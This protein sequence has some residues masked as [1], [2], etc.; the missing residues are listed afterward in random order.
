MPQSLA[1]VVVH[2][3]FSTKNRAPLLKSPE[4]R[5][6]LH[7]YSVGTLKN[8][9]CRSIITRSVEDHI[10][11]LCHLSRTM[12]IAQLIKEIKA[13][14][15]AWLKEQDPC[16]HDFYWQAGYGAFSVSRSNVEKVKDYIADQEEHHRTRTFQEEFRLLLE[17][18]G[19]EYD[20]RYV[21]D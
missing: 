6:R 7:A 19:I 3:V 4:V 8:L 5:E 9:D 14:S 15:S 13:S 21:W 12:T 10:H 18:H 17:R 2:I 11:I 16:L 1:D 20:E